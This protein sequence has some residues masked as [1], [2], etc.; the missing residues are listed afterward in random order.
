MQQIIDYVVVYERDRQKLAKSV[1]ALVEKGWQPQGGV[2]YE[3]MLSHYLQ[4]MVLYRK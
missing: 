3:S 2:G 1:M 4:A